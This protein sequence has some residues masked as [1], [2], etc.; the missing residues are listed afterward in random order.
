MSSKNADNRNKKIKLKPHQQFVVEYMRKPK[1]KGLILYHTTGSGKTITS[2]KSMLQYDEQIIII[3]KKSSKKAF[4]DDMK[5][6]G[7]SFEQEGIDAEPR[8]IFYTF[9]KMKTI[10]KEDLAYLAN[11]SII[12]DE[13]HNLR[14]ETSNNLLV[15]HAI[16]LSS[17]VILL[18]A[19]P[20]INYLNDLCVLV[21]MAKDESI[22]PT[23]IDSFNAAYY[24]S[25]SNSIES[26]DVL[27][28]KLSNSISYYDHY[29][30]TRDYPSHS[31]EYIEVEMIYDQL[32]EYK[33]Y[34]KK[35]FFDVQLE[36]RGTGKG[37]YYV[38][39]GDVYARKKN[40]F[41]SG[42][43]QLSN[44]LN[45]D[46]DYPKIKALHDMILKQKKN[47][48]TPM[49][50]YSNYLENGVYAL[51]KRLERS[52][53]KYKT[54]TGSTSDDKINFV[55][56]DYNRGKI[57]VL[58]ITSAGSESLDLKNTRAI[59][60]MEPHWNESR[61]KQVIGRAIRFKSHSDLP[62]SERHVKIVR[63][64]SVFPDTIANKSADEYLIELSR[65]KDEIFQ[66]FDQ[67]I[68]DAAIENNDID[69][70]DNFQ[71]LKKQGRTVSVVRIKTDKKKKRRGQGGGYGGAMRLYDRYL[72]NRSEYIDLK[73]IIDNE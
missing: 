22:L 69:K 41:L 40:F 25:R 43:R 73:R 50:V 28:K 17:R 38:D 32:M 36:F 12:V 46:P 70:Y 16:S 59:H 42:T 2:L 34:I 8:F 21:N 48:L 11:K 39:F 61:I 72:T 15:I 31:V 35:Y 3:G 24:N 6:I 23:D 19:T 67:I 68:Q 44:T 55:V 53:I 5:K 7:V 60:I 62:E 57:D 49:V 10:L 54:I 14:N 51:T 9:T 4:K 20:V 27:V 29:K 37:E 64:S 1:H 30:N 66:V 58:L 13:A 18:T 47:K 65:N 63:W 33:K 71:S 52:G 56:D 45:G 26:P